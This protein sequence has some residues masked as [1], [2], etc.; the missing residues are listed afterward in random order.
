[1]EDNT[2]TESRRMQ[3]AVGAR[4]L[5]RWHYAV[6]HLMYQ[7]G[8]EKGAEHIASVIAVRAKWV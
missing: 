4:W 3:D 2:V 1:M 6:W 7:I 5:I 8:G